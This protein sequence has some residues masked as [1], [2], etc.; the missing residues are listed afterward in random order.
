MYRELYRVLY[1]MPCGLID[2]ISLLKQHSLTTTLCIEYSCER[3]VESAGDRRGLKII[4]LSIKTT[5]LTSSHS[6][7]VVS[8]ST[9]LRVGEGERW[10]NNLLELVPTAYLERKPMMQVL[11]TWCLRGV[12][13]A[14]GSEEICHGINQMSAIMGVRGRAMMEWFVEIE[15]GA[16]MRDDLQCTT[17]I[18]RRTVYHVQCTYHVQ[19]AHVE[20]K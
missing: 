12:Y 3:G 14:R 10:L 15:R 17:Y 16:W 2:T 20:G 8:Q 9:P 11:A 1:R 7:I 13:G 4:G 5:P 19:C 18:I 6:P